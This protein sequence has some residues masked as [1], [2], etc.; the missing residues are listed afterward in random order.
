LIISSFGGHVNCQGG[1]AKIV[2]SLL[3]IPSVLGDGVIL[4][5]SEKNLFGHKKSQLVFTGL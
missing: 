2:T 3:I 5:Q 4:K 1:G